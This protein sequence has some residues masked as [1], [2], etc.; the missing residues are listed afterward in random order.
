MV[1]LS[2]CPR[3]W[4][5]LSKYSNVTLHS[6][7]CQCYNYLPSKGAAVN[8]CCSPSILRILF[9]VEHSYK[10]KV[11]QNW[12]SKCQQMLTTKNHQYI[13]ILT[14]E[15]VPK[16]LHIF[17]IDLNTR[18]M[19]SFL[20]DGIFQ[21][22]TT[23]DALH[24]LHRL[25]DHTINSSYNHHVGP[26]HIGTN[27]YY[28]CLVSRDNGEW[29]LRSFH[30]NDSEVALRKSTLS[31]ARAANTTHYV[32][33]RQRPSANICA[34]TVSQHLSKPGSTATRVKINI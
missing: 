11:M 22:S 25:C 29:P 34:R 7:H 1:V 13:I 14:F 10:H 21:L 2:F 31:A 19:E 15:L 28:W 6:H 9:Q 23:H 16:A 4:C 24:Q 3:A 20:L 8:G 30:N 17:N 27:R 12:T 18:K 33:N 26:T 5:Q 32:V